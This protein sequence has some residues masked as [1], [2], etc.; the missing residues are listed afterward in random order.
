MCGESNRTLEKNCIT[1]DSFGPNF[2]D[3]Y[4]DKIKGNKVHKICSLRGREEEYIQ[5]IR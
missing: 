5:N 2:Y 1:R 3:S 4:S